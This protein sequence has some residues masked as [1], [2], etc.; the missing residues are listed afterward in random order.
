LFVFLYIGGVGGGSPSL[1]K[2]FSFLDFFSS[3]FI[4]GYPK[5]GLWLGCI[6]FLPMVVVVVVIELLAFPFK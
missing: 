4:H 6:L 1:P 3:Y 2:A 5:I